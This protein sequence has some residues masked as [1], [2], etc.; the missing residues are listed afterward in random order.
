MKTIATIALAALL[1]GSATY[2]MA[3][4]T[5]APDAPAASQD[6]ARTISTGSSTPAL[7]R[8]RPA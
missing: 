8:S 4:Q 3:Q 7:P 2:A 5:P 1:A 6:Q